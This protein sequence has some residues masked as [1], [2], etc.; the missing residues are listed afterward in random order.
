MALTQRYE[1]K[2]EITELGVIQIRQA[3]IIEDDGVYV[4]TSYNRSVVAPGDDVSAQ[5]SEVQAL[6]AVMHTEARVTAYEA[7]TSEE[8]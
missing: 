2:Y 8:D 4:A 3:T 6:A 1:Y 7:L 5:S